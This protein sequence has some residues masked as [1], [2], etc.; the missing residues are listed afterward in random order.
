MAIGYLLQLPPK[1]KKKPC[2]I[3]WGALLNVIGLFIKVTVQ[4]FLP[5]VVIYRRGVFLYHHL[6]CTLIYQPLSYLFRSLV[7]EQYRAR[8][9]IWQLTKTHKERKQHF[10]ISFFMVISHKVPVE[11]I[12]PHPLLIC[13][14][15]KGVIFL[16]TLRYYSLPNK[17]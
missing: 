15:K 6:G 7:I 12:S 16:P 3:R 10:I 14:W 2:L 8:I 5:L 9:D 13:K 11:L 17:T 1:F 4:K